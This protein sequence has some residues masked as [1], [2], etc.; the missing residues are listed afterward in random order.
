MHGLGQSRV[1]E[2][3]EQGGDNFPGVLSMIS[4]H[5]KRLPGAPSP[6][7][8][9]AMERQNERWGAAE[10]PDRSGRKPVTRPGSNAGAKEGGPMAPAPTW[11]GETHGVHLKRLSHTG[12]RGAADEGGREGPAD[13]S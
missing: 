13:R 8:A 11:K 4:L 6:P 5:L 2:G 12:P 10:N 1:L 9:V 3:R 7:A